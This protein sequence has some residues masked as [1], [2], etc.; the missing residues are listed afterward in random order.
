MP[1]FRGRMQA[2]STP[3]RVRRQVRAQM[4]RSYQGSPSI[5]YARPRS[6]QRRIAQDRTYYRA[7]L[8]R[9]RAA[10]QARIQRNRRIAARNAER[11]RNQQKYRAVRARQQRRTQRL[12]GQR[13]RSQRKARLRQNAT[14]LALPPRYKANRQQRQDLAQML[15][16]NAVRPNARPTPRVRFNGPLGPGLNTQARGLVNRAQRIERRDSDLARIQKRIER[17]LIGGRTRT[18]RLRKGPTRLNLD[19]SG[20][21][22]LKKLKRPYEPFPGDARPKKRLGQPR[23]RGINRPPKAFRS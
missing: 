10:N 20:K 7:R 6:T 9:N 1:D 5:P 15:L 4:R 11:A 23:Y 14:R 19:K 22:K 21:P 8:Q 12:A 2:K 16:R 13:A 18:H 17:N 3:R